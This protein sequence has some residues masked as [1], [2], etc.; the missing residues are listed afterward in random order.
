[1]Q[2]SFST[3]LVFQLTTFI[4]MMFLYATAAQAVSA[5][6]LQF[7]PASSSV[8][9]EESFTVEVQ[10]NPGTAQIAGTDIYLLYDPAFLELQTI[11]AGSYFPLVNNI[12]SSGRVY[13]S[14]V[15]A[16]QGEFKTGV[17]TVAS[18]SFKALQ[19]GSTTLR[20]D[21]D[22]TKTDTSKIV[23]NDINAT[24]IIDCA[25]NSTHA[26]TI[27]AAGTGT[28]GTG[29]GGTGGTGS[30]SELPQSGVTETMVTFATTGG[31]LLVVGLM[32]RSLIFL[33]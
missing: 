23:Q 22:L 28:G 2:K 29:T 31:L 17:G 8:A 7:N 14:G 25:T 9:D 19:T 27:G 20:Y 32:I 13:I 24:N 15:V 18:V 16:N 6:S 1:M 12:P 4:V 11:T 21:C 5:A 3:K 30:G 10:V 26:V 33:L